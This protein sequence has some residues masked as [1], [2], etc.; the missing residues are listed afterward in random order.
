MNTVVEH[1]YCRDQ[2]QLIRYFLQGVIPTSWQPTYV[3]A[4]SRSMFSQMM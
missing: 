1:D 2:A 4:E 3:A